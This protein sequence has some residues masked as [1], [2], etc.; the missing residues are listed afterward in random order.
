MGKAVCRIQLQSKAC[1]VI[2]VETDVKCMEL[3]CL[4]LLLLY[5]CMFLCDALK[6]KLGKENLSLLGLWSLQSVEM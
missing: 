2:V 3:K 5:I 6:G 1:N 4:V